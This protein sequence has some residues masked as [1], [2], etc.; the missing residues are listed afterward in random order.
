MNKVDITLAEVERICR[1]YDETFKG[2]KKFSHTLE[3]EW[4][5]KR[6]WVW[7]GLGL[8]VTV[9]E[10]YLKDLVNRVVQ[11]TGHDIHMKALRIFKQI[12]SRERIPFTWI[13]PD[14]HDQLVIECKKS[15]ADRIFYLMNTELCA[16]L[17]Q[18]LGGL[19]EIKGTPQIVQNLAEAK[20][21]T[22]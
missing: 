1:V 22:P 14:F 17:N 7:S 3:T 12:M 19:I 2:V 16:T 10:D 6:G 20:E 11:K 18:E 13:I 5:E 4:K 9:S 21:L 15:D 8:P